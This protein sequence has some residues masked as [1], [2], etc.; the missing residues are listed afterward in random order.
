MNEIEGFPRLRLR[1]NHES[2]CSGGALLAIY[3]LITGWY[4][5]EL[6]RLFYFQKI[7]EKHKVYLSYVRNIP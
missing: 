7:E 6:P 1:L 4:N 3:L 2:Y 5:Q